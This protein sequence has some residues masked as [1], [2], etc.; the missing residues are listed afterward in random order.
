MCQQ[1]SA[2]PSAPQ[3]QLEQ[4]M[5]PFYRVE[6]SRNAETGGYGLGLSIAHT[7]ARAH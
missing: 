4:V 6:G 1:N 7:I 2:A 5:E 3:E